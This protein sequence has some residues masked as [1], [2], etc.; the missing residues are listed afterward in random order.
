M[1]SSSFF[2]PPLP[3]A[4]PWAGPE[5]AAAA[6]TAARREPEAS[7]DPRDYAWGAPSPAQRAA[8]H[9]QWTH[10]AWLTF[11]AWQAQHAA[12]SCAYAMAPAY[13][14]HGL[15]ACGPLPH[16]GGAV[17]GGARRLPAAPPRGG[18]AAAFA[19]ARLDAPLPL[20]LFPAGH[21]A[22]FG[23]RAV[24]AASGG[25]A[26]RAGGP[27]AAGKSLSAFGCAGDALA[28][29]AD[30]FAA[31]GGAG[32]GSPSGEDDG[33]ALSGGLGSGDDDG[34]MDVISSLLAGAPGGG[35]AYWAPLPAL[36]D[37]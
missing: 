18:A 29:V 5:A 22:V 21:G 14:A 3:A 4:G 30:C 19:D 17:L 23:F 36:L 9:A 11:A 8:M 20:P 10:M 31:P 32:S 16:G 1:A 7:L 34:G 27:G 33:T 37:A 25:V 12:M 2:A 28:A 35:D 15:P 13:G 6:C 26:K 24:P